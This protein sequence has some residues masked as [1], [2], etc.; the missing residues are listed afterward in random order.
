MRGQRNFYEDPSQMF[1][2]SILSLRFWKYKQNRVH[3]SSLKFVQ[4]NRWLVGLSLAASPRVV[5]KTT[6]KSL[7][8]T[9]TTV[10]IQKLSQRNFTTLFVLHVLIEHSTFNR[11]FLIKYFNVQL[12]K[13]H[14]LEAFE[15]DF[16]SG[17]F[18]ILIRYWIITV[19]PACRALTV[20]HTALDSSHS[21]FLAV[22]TALKRDSSIFYYR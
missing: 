3:Y 11:M 4:L 9:Y 15:M 12:V 20:P 22:H 2:V 5:F 16:F 14:V 1:C 18:H 6:P 13:L 8:V 17:C 21:L 7:S 19:F 10:L